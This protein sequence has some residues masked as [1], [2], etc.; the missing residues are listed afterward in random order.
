[1]AVKFTYDVLL[2]VEMHPTDIYAMGEEPLIEPNGRVYL[3]LQEWRAGAVVDDDVDESEA[4]RK[5]IRT[6]CFYFKAENPDWQEHL[7]VGL[8][9]DLVRASVLRD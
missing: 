5:A 9:P 4:R 2:A 7:L 1:M 6:A 8:S 3:P